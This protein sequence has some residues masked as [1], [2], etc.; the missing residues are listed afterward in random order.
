MK[1]DSSGYKANGKP[2]VQ[3]RYL[4]VPNNSKK[5]RYHSLIKVSTIAVISAR[6]V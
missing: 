5:L 4:R 3:S 2:V 1:V 6:Y